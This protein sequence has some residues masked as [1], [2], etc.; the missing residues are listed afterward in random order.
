[1]LTHKNIFFYQKV[2]D[3]GNGFQAIKQNRNSPMRV[4]ILF[5]AKT[6]RVSKRGPRLKKMKNIRK[7][8]YIF[9]ILIGGPF[10]IRATGMIYVGFLE[11]CSNPIGRK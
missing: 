2:P 1:M 4:S 7:T 8:L 3:S 9:R 5:G 11:M 6:L 10:L